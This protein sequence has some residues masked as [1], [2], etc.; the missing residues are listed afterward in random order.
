MGSFGKG[1]L[2]KIFRNFQRNFR[3]LSAE[4]PHPFLTQYNISS[5]NF[6]KFSAE[7]P[8]TFRKNP[9]ANDPISE[10][11]T[12]RRLPCGTG[13]L[14]EQSV[15]HCFHCCC[16]GNCTLA[17]TALLLQSLLLLRSLC[18]SSLLPVR[19]LAI[20][21]LGQAIDPTLNL[22]K[23]QMVRRLGLTRDKSRRR[24]R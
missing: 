8:Q 13:P 22:R 24:K 3:K 10:L 5:A 7:F 6:R 16:H 9:F 17:V 4:F 23:W 19:E 1:S 2:Q 18:H 21:L 20:V 15:Q 11:L 12:K 14:S